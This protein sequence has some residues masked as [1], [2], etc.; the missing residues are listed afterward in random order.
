MKRN[1][2]E[3]LSGRGMRPLHSSPLKGPLHARLGAW[4]RIEA[5]TSH[6]RF[7]HAASA[8]GL[9]SE[10]HRRMS[11]RRATVSNG[12]QRAEG[13]KVEGRDRVRSATINGAPARPIRDRRTPSEP[14]VQL[15]VGAS[16]SRSSSLFPLRPLDPPSPVARSRTKLS[17]RGLFTR[18]LDVRSS[19][20]A[21]RD[22]PA[23]YTRAGRITIVRPP[24]WR[25]F[26]NATAV[27]LWR[28]RWKTPSSLKIT[29]PAKNVARGNSFA[30][31]WQSSSAASTA[32]MP[33]S[34]RSVDGT[35]S[36]A[37]RS[38]YFCSIDVVRFSRLPT[39]CPPLNT[40]ESVTPPEGKSRFLNW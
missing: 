34:T 40:P 30:T 27:S 20:P 33:T 10:L 2:R 1:R 12:G 24:K 23:Q 16:V 37:P 28:K 13:K 19:F 21:S 17:P 4:V 22:A 32:S 29:F 6:P 39:A 8:I 31:A 5:E 38:T 26:C 15:L 36:R 35:P 18:V 3:M 25:R 14:P 11:R 7:V 9:R